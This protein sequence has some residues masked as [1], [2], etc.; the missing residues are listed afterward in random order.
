MTDGTSLGWNRV[1]LDAVAPMPWRNGG[2]TTRELAAWPRGTDDWRWRV[3]VA[4]VVADGP[5]SR[6]EGVSRW[7]AVLSGAGVR[8]DLG[9]RS[10]RLL[11]SSD[12]LC[13]DGALAAS[14]TL[15]DGATQDFNLMTRV[16]AAQARLVRVRGARQLSLARTLTMAV[17][18]VQGPASLKL[19]GVAMELPARAL[20]WQRL[21]AD[22]ALCLTAPHALWME[23]ET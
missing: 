2:G 23:I 14:C 13:F 17:Y 3:S 18:V 16:G 9:A 15:V 20:V 21:E 22:S 10:H 11:A 1:D 7:F 4:E 12:P 8:L 6:F 5:F 19:D